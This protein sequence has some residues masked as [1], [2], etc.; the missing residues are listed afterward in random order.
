MS[1]PEGISDDQSLL[2]LGTHSI[3]PHE[4]LDLFQEPIVFHRVYVDITGSVTA[5]L[6][7]SYAVYT[8]DNLPREAEGWFVKTAEAWQ[9]ETGL[10]RHELQS[11]RNLLR[12]L[13]LMLERR[14]GMPSQLYY[15]VDARVLIERL[16]AASESR[17]GR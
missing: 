5:A 17:W 2:E 14:Q 16:R 8:T 15:K 1:F 11:A 3:H 4:V 13:G 9:R 7:L 12:R 6:L 10:S